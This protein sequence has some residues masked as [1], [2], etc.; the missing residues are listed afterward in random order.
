MPVSYEVP[1]ASN[2]HILNK[3]LISLFSTLFLPGNLAPD[4]L[5]TGLLNLGI[6]GTKYY[7]PHSII[8]LGQE[9]N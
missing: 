8:E 3:Y 5:P 7:G 1:E 4:E 9:I 6:T 2:V